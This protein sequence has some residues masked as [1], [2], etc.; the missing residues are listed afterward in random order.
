MR[1]EMT[2]SLS[3]RQECRLE[4]SLRVLVNEF[5]TKP[6]KTQGEI[7]NDNLKDVLEKL[8]KT[9]EKDYWDPVRFT[10]IVNREVWRHRLSQEGTTFRR[11]FKDLVETYEPDH[12][13]AMEL[14]KL[15]WTKGDDETLPGQVVH[16]WSSLANP[17]NKNGLLELAR[18]LKAKDIEIVTPFDLL[19]LVREDQQAFTATTVR[20]MRYARDDARMIDFT[21]KTAKPLL[22]KISAADLP[23]LFPGIE[24]WYM[25]DKQLEEREGLDTVVEFLSKGQEIDFTLPLPILAFA[26]RLGNPTALHSFAEHRDFKEGR[27]L[28]RKMYHGLAAL[29][30]HKKGQ[31]IYAH[32]TKHM[33]R[34]KDLA[35]ALGTLDILR[36]DEQ[37]QYNFTNQEPKA[38]LKSLKLQLADKNVRKIG[39]QEEYLEK[40]LDKSQEAAYRMICQVATALAGYYQGKTGLMNTLRQVTEAALDSNPKNW[41]VFRN[42]R[43]HG[44]LAE[45]T[46]CRLAGPGNLLGREF[47]SNQNRW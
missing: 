20:V 46:T 19:Y 45:K 34:A 32:L 16:H 28:Q 2:T 42:W 5:K 11:G 41:D 25:L 24:Q 6:F 29:A 39:L 4:L 22:R 9:K 13:L 10:Q 1:M 3:L 37:F 33:T 27:E 35:S 26:D 44:E 30:L 31:Q 15:L 8:Q 17:E 38:I 21:H 43:Y 40:F 7:D 18:D 47:F 14:C 12:P 23:Q 36:R